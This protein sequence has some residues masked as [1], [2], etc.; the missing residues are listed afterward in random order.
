MISHAEKALARVRAFVTQ[1]PKSASALAREAGLSS[2]G[3]Y[4]AGTPDWDPRVS[5][6]ARVEKI[7]PPDF[8]PADFTPGAPSPAAPEGGAA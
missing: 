4:R 1:S 6:V 2:G 5:T 3:L 8:K 7:I